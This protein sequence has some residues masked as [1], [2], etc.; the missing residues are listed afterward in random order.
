MFEILSSLYRHVKLIYK[1]ENNNNKMKNQNYVSII[2]SPTK[3]RVS[4]RISQS[5]V[6][7]ESDLNKKSLGELV[8]GRNFLFIFLTLF[9]LLT[10]TT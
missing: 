2:D 9:L 3:S 10:Y 8:S 7:I 1:K 6:E 4:T 5:F